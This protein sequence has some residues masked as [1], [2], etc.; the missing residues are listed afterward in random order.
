MSQGGGETGAKEHHARMTQTAVL[1][2]IDRAMKSPTLPTRFDVPE[3]IPVER[4]DEVV[5]AVR[6]LRRLYQV[7][8]IEERR[9]DA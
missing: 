2:F 3:T 8:V 7:A 4:R 6:T 1:E 5:G 9:R